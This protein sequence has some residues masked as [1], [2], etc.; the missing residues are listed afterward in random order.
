MFKKENFLATKSFYSKV[1][2]V[3][4][5]IMIQNG[6]TNLVGMLDNI[7]VGQVGTNQ[8]SGVAIVNQLLFVF[9]LMIFGGLAGI[10]IFT[11]QYVGRGD[12]E[13]IRI[14]VRMKILMALIL[15]GLGLIFF[16]TKGV[17]LAS[18]WLTKSSDKASMNETLNAARNYLFTICISLIPFAIGQVYSGTL[19][20]CGE[21][22]TPMKAGIVAIVVNLIGNYLLIYGKFG[23]P[24]LGVVGAATATVISR[25]VEVIYV[26]VWLSK[27]KARYSFIKGL[28]S[29]FYIPLDVAKKILLKAWPLLLNETLWSLGNTVLSQQYS[30][31]GF[32]V[33]AAFNIHS[34]L[35][36]VCNIGFI[37]LGDAI[38]IILGQGLG[39]GKLEKTREEANK[40]IVFSVEVCIIMGLVMFSLSNVFPMLYKTE[41]EI[42]QMASSLIKIGAIFMPVYA[43]ENASYFTIRSGGK[44]FITFLF[45]AG[46]VWVCSL[47]LA[48]V[49]THFTK[50]DIITAFIIVQSAEFIKCVVAYLMVKSGMWIHDLTQEI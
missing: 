19:R 22:L 35:A 5:P 41:N 43:F 28:Y 12:D 34:T 46:F 11:A 38:A 48:F 39:S 31:L 30:R 9:Y 2:K 29:R 50:V 47:P 15:S 33:V 8:M 6:I 42:K 1:L 10:G 14:T 18:L 49:I 37:A 17:D 40:L 24:K 25:F 16:L 4:I 27:N 7:M 36:N 44:T 23:L 13:G 45:D 21:T 26:V 3:A 32:S 20:E